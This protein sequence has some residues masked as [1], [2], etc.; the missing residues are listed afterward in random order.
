MLQ[1]A[2]SGEGSRGGTEGEQMVRDL[3]GS[4]QALDEKLATSEIQLFGRPA[5]GAGAKMLNGRAQL[6]NGE[7]HDDDLEKGL[8]AQSDDEDADESET[9]PGM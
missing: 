2:F 5:T 1:V 7:G 3:Q 8:G 9:E 4:R 6:G